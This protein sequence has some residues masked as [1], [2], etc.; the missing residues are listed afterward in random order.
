MHSLCGVMRR[1]ALGSR[2]SITHYQLADF[3]ENAPAFPRICVLSNG[4]Q[5]LKRS[6][7]P[8]SALVRR[9]YVSSSK[10]RFVVPPVVKPKPLADF[11]N[12]PTMVLSIPL[13]RRALRGARCAARVA[14]GAVGGGACYA[15]CSRLLPPLRRYLP[16]ILVFEEVVGHA[17]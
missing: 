15:W 11:V 4:R 14:R 2:G 13:M 5:R 9:A 8:G 3:G 12:A 10:F 7:A 16:I 17:E 1:F 6:Q